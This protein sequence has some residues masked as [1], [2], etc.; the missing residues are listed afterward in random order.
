MPFQEPNADL[1]TAP[2]VL[3][4]YHRLDLTV[5]LGYDIDLARGRLFFKACLECF[6]MLKILI[7]LLVI[8]SMKFL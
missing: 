5:D 2:Q 1:E 8:F 3:P 6:K 4:H 7:K